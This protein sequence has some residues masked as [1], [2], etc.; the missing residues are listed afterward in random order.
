VVKENGHQEP[1]VEKPGAFVTKQNPSAIVMILQ[2]FSS[3]YR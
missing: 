2:V 1:L 3:E